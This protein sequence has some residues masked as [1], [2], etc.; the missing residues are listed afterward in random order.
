MKNIFEKLD[1]GLKIK[2]KNCKFL[3]MD[4][5]GVLT[6]NYVFVDSGGNEIV[7]CSRYDSLGLNM[8]KKNTDIKVALLS[9]EKNQVVSARAK[10]LDIDC[11]QGIEHKAIF[12][13]K[14]ITL[15]KISSNEV[16]YIG[17]DLNDLECFSEVGLSIAVS[18]AD[19][20]VK[21]KASYITKFKGGNGAIR[22]VCEMILYA[23]KSHP[24]DKK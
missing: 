2:F 9:R 22:E 8:L 20:R 3:V 5:D 4:F 6:D 10:K 24:F 23:Q 1:E 14:E 11:F 18:D 12:L 21:K 7:R 19:P 16:C 13:K 17:N 15:R